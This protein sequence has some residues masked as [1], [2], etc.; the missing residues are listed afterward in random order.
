MLEMSDNIMKTCETINNDTVT[1]TTNNT[2][3]KIQC[4]HKLKDLNIIFLDYSND[5]LLVLWKYLIDIFKGHLQ[6]EC[7][8]TCDSCK[9][10]VDFYDKNI[11]TNIYEQMVRPKKLFYHCVVKPDD[12]LNIY[13]HY[14]NTIIQTASF[15]NYCT[16]IMA[17][18][19]SVNQL[20]S[21]EKQMI[22][23]ADVIIASSVN[24]ISNVWK[25]VTESLTQL[26]LF[27]FNNIHLATP[28]IISNN[29]LE[30]L[31]KVDNV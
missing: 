13:Q 22:V 12:Q 15:H 23:Q 17:I 11:E 10:M 26:Q 4:L 16:Y 30:K 25:M 3:I 1:D 20:T 31:Q 7:S 9:N 2:T 27:S 21:I 19:H 5:D 6:T 14:N 8:S 28:L 24:S 18:D 29:I